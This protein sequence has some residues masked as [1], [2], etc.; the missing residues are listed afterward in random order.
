MFDNLGSI[1][2][3]SSKAKGASKVFGKI[4]P[5]KVPP[6]VKKYIGLY[7]WHHYAGVGKTVIKPS[8]YANVG[9][10]TKK[11]DDE[12]R[13]EFVERLASLVR[14]AW[15]NGVTP[16]NIVKELPAYKKTEPENADEDVHMEGD[17]DSDESS[18]EETDDSS[19]NE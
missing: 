10:L 16:R 4:A 13:K 12:T 18:D 2:V 11:R 9:T 3:V 7:H 1:P 14:Q 19:D 6:L 17:S 5:S 15:P 8:P